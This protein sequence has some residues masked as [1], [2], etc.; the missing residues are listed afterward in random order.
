MRNFFSKIFKIFQPQFILIW[1]LM[2][3][4]VAFSFLSSSFRAYDNLFE[5]LRTSCNTAVLVLGLT[6]IIAMNEI[7]VA[8]PDIAAFGS[9]VTA[10]CAMEGLPWSLSI[11]IALL[12]SAFFG[13]ISGMLINIFKVPSLIATIGITTIA[14]SA[15]YII[16]KGSP[17]YFSKIDPTVNFLVYGKI[18]GIP[19]LFIIV[20]LLYIL[21]AFLQN[22][23]KL[24]Q[25]LY[26]LGENRQAA[27]EAGI[28][29]K[30]IIYAFFLLSATLASLGG[31]LLLASFSSGQPN[32]QGSYFVDGL[33]AVFL[34]ALTIK[35]GKPNVIGTLIGAIIIST[36]T[37]GLTLLGVPFYV[38]IIIKG[39]LMLVGV[40]MI[41]AT[42][43]PFRKATRKIH[44]QSYSSP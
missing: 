36:L 11:L 13:L 25:Y 5:I 8:F 4:I 16:G 29:G 30:T 40:V 15:A 17:I 2:A 26:A 3:L 35:I 41:V 23:T 20:L 43:Y 7:D 9:M 1:T 18:Y 6:W 32:F 19:V 14:K 39:L 28:P 21:A 33:S 34:G 38:G 27:F 10:F 24:G 12:T 31:V 37:N 22:R 44:T 42:R